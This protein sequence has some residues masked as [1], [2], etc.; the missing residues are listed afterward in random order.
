MQE[1][2]GGVTVL[3]RWPRRSAGAI[4]LVLAGLVL[5]PQVS[6][7]GGLA[8]I[9][10][11]AA[12]PRAPLFSYLSRPDVVLTGPLLTLPAILLIPL[13]R[14]ASLIA[15]RLAHAEASRETP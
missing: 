8:G 11:L 7:H 1:M 10:L 13:G 6:V 4:L 3:W 9:V 12:K 14:E 5:L 15:D 2:R